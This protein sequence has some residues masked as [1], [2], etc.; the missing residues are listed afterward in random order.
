MSEEVVQL[1]SKLLKCAPQL[2]REPAYVVESLSIHGHEKMIMDLYAH[3]SLGRSHQTY[4]RAMLLRAMRHFQV[5]PED[6]LFSVLLASEEPIEA[7]LLAS[8]TLL[9]ANIDGLSHQNWAK[10]NN[11]LSNE[12]LIPRFKKNLILLLRQVRDRDPQTFRPQP[13][14]DQVCLMHSKKKTDS[15]FLSKR[16]HLNLRSITTLISQTTHMN[17]AN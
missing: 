9:A 6:L 8:E 17:T 7:R 2:L 13:G 1:I 15:V 11:V 3:F 4:M 10:I 12:R 16:N 14:D 5:V